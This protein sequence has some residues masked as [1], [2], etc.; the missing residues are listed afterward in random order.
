[1][2]ISGNLLT[3]LTQYVNWL[4]TVLIDNENEWVNIMSTH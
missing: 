2:Q 3:Y 4:G 1:M